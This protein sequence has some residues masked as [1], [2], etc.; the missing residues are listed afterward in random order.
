MVDW[1]TLNDETK[2]LTKTDTETCFLKP[3]LFSKTKFSG[4]ETEALQKLTKVSK[5]RSFETEMSRSGGIF[6]K[7]MNVTKEKVLDFGM[8]VEDILL[9]VRLREGERVS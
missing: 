2:N 6:L 1:N 7:R 3:S 8:N 9:F 4:T 5:P